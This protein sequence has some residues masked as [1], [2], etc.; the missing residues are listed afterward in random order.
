MQEGIA[1][2]NYNEA[3]NA[4]EQRTQLVS[5]RFKNSGS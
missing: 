3:S 5:I 2:S 1:V 4:S